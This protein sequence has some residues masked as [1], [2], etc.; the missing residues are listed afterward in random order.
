MASDNQKA[1]VNLVMEIEK[2]IDS[3]GK[4]PLRCLITP[5]SFELGIE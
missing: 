1:A 4:F 5:E 2:Q 3:L